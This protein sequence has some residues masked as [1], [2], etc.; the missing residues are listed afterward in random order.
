M[1][2]LGKRY[3]ISWSGRTPGMSKHDREIWEKWKKDYIAYPVEVYYNVRFG[4]TPKGVEEFDPASQWHWW[5]L[6]C[7]RADVVLIDSNDVALIEIR[8]K[9]TETAIAR[10]L[11]YDDLWQLHDEAERVPSLCLVTD[12]RN[13]QT[14]EL[15][16][17]HAIE[18]WV[19]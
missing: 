12:I 6:C 16:R 19:V 5:R 1:I 11:V 15:A 2:E 4:H 10:L 14:A 3:D 8:H 18:Y 17:Q 7:R 9:A 13:D